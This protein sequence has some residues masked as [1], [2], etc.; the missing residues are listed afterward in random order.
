MKKILCSFLS[1][2]LLL[3]C[4]GGCDSLRGTRE[5]PTTPANDFE[6]RT[7]SDGG[8]TITKYI[9]KGGAVAIPDM[10]NASPVTQIGAQAFISSLVVSL[11]MPDTVKLIGEYAFA[12]CV[13]L[14]SVTLSNSLTKIDA[15]AFMGC[16]SLRH[17]RIPVSV[18]TISDS[19]FADCT[20]L[21]SVEFYEGLEQI[22]PYA[23]H[24]TGLSKLIL[25][26]SVKA[27]GDGAFSDCPALK[28]VTLNDGLL[29]IGIEAFAKDL[30]LAEIVIPKTVTTVTNAAFSGC[31][32]LKKVTF[33]GDAPDS[34]LY[35]AEAVPHISFCPVEY[36][37]YYHKDAKGFTSP[38]WAGFQTQ[39]K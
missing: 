16:F 6:Y 30:K 7:N 17:V 38:E 2:V 1:V 5:T 35:D 24:N 25:P 3:I 31:S 20:R 14:E 11:T 13:Y 15:S 34:Y 22:F 4:L 37:V 10:I 8:V 26:K 36:T 28:T 21:E 32:G 9:G 29:T 18:V 12:G 23:F 19:A 39:V 33:D 27:I